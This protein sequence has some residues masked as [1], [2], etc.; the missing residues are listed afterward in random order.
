MVRRRW[1]EERAQ[2]YRAGRES[3][4]DK[5]I[6]RGRYGEPV[7]QLWVC[8]LECWDLLSEGHTRAP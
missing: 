7:L 1:C 6:A 4:Q 3:E 2:R 5:N 8:C